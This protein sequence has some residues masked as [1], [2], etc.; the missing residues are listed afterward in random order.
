M[1]SLLWCGGFIWGEQNRDLIQVKGTREKRTISFNFAMTCILF[2]H[3]QKK[4]IFQQDNDPKTLFSIIAKLC[5]GHYSELYPTKK[6]WD[7]LDKRIS[8]EYT[9]SEIEIF[10]CLKDNWEGSWK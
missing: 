3:N 1:V 2:M 7:E 10:Q 8:R 5:L 6:E 9:N 4:N